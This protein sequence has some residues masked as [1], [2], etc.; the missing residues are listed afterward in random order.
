MDNKLKVVIIDDE[1]LAR[2][3]V[4]NYVL[5]TGTL[6]LLAEC[7]NGFEALKII[8]EKKPDLI[9]LD[10]QMPKINGF[11]MLELLDDP[12]QV[13]FT[14]A[15]DEFALKAF[16]VNAVDYLLK[17][18]TRERF[19]LA[20]EKSLN[21][22]K[23]LFPAS[24]E[25]LKNVLSSVDE[26]KENIERI[27]VKKNNKIYVIPLEKIYFIEAQDD[28][29]LIHSEIGKFLKQ[30]TMKFFET[31]LN[32]SEFIRTHRSNIV[33]IGCIKQ[34]ELVGKDSYQLTISSGEKLPVSKS[35]YAR[36]KEL[37]R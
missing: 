4:K 20:V 11:E 28:Y 24:K 13:I 21:Q 30:K 25:R 15:F 2:E 14:T 23:E 36:L 19:D 22:M 32:E 34:L 9:F 29:V 5:Q 37:L 6:E 27:V 12:P 35:G 1:I 8:N 31:H 17:P 10:V 3:I 16:E 26:K 33:N 18:F 7:E